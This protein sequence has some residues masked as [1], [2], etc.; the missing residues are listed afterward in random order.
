MSGG[1]R[2]LIHALLRLLRMPH[3]GFGVD[4]DVERAEFGADLLLDLVAD[5]VDSC[6]VHVAVEE[7]VDV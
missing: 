7:D 5:G 3:V 6:E 1:V 2:F 4:E